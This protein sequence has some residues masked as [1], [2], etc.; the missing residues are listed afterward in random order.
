MDWLV[1]AALILGMFVLRLVV[2]LAITLAIGYWLRRLDAKWQAEAQ[3]RRDATVESEIRLLRVIKEPCWV[4]KAC[5][6]AIYPHCPAYHD[7]DIPCWLA[8]FRAG[9]SI[10]A[11][12]Y[13]CPLFSQKQTS[14]HLFQGHRP[15]QPG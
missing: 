9:G 11:A 10:P 1:Q 5:P 3:V 4:T 8:R 12:C 15:N 14:N 6:E 13:R 2:P 7:P